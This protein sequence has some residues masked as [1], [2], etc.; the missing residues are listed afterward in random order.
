MSAAV[1]FGVMGAR[2]EVDVDENGEFIGREL[3]LEEVDP[4]SRA[5]PP[6]SDR[7]CAKFDD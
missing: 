5:L 7:L 6:R 2:V 4:G 3:L 1:L